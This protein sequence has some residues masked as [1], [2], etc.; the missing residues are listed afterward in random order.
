VRIV[1]LYICN[2]DTALGT[3]RLYCDRC[4]CCVVLLRV[5][6]VFVSIEMTNVVST[7]PEAD[8]FTSVGRR[9]HHCDKDEPQQEAG[10]TCTT[11]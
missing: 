1:W 5:S 7:S 11:H 6:S 3:L 9:S 8:L 2:G 4:S 10:D